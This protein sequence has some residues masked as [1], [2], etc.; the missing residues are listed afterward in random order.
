MFNM[1]MG[2][3]LLENVWI[4]QLNFVKKS[5][6]EAVCVAQKSLKRLVRRKWYWNQ[7]VSFIPNFKIFSCFYPKNF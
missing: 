6:A 5:M 3:P 2:N 7:Y 1:A 4:S